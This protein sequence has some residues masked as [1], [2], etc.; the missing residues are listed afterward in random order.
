[1]TG[2]LALRIEKA[3]KA[4]YDGRRQKLDTNIIIGATDDN[5]GNTS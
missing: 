5:T 3:K 4:H 1:M 2:K